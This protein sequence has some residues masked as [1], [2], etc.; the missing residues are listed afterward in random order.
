MSIAFAGSAI[1]FLA[2]AYIV[3]KAS[4]KLRRVRDGIVGF[5][6]EEAKLFVSSAERP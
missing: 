4:K 5:V 6:L 3:R 1:V 2:V